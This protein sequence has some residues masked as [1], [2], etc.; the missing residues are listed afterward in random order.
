MWV[1]NESLVLIR[2]PRWEAMKNTPISQNLPSTKCLHMGLQMLQKWRWLDHTRSN[3]VTKPG[4]QSLFNIW[5]KSSQLI[6]LHPRKVQVRTLVTIHRIH[7]SHRKSHTDSCQ[8]STWSLTV[9]ALPSTP[10]PPYSRS[11]VGYHYPTRSSRAGSVATL[12]APD[13]WGV[14]TAWRGTARQ[15]LQHPRRSG[16]LVRSCPGHSYW[17]LH[18]TD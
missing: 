4:I 18:A 11:A 9:S 2:S 15:W 3:S 6:F 1:P 16:G 13:F 17:V 5:R 8:P 10:S 12:M 7:I 14:A